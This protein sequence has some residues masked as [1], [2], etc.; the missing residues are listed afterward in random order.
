VERNLVMA[1]PQICVR[2]S[3]TIV[4][5]TGREYDSRPSP[6]SFLPFKS[7]AT[8]QTTTIFLILRLKSQFRKGQNG[9]S[10]RFWLTRVLPG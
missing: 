9:L 3:S 4:K 7:E 10:A 6:N 1:K 8:W 5:T 2:S